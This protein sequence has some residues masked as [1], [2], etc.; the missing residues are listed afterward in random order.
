MNKIQNIT[1]C[2][3]CNLSF[4]TGYEHTKS[5]SL[6]KC[7]GCKY[8]FESKRTALHNGGDNIFFK[9]NCPAMM[10]DGRF[11]TMYDSTNE[12][13]ENMRKKLGIDNTN[14]FRNVIQD[15][16]N[17]II[18]SD[19]KNLYSNNSCTPSFSCSEGWAKLGLYTNTD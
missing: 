4:I 16:A 13:T 14:V 3:D 11:L 6:I 8:V 9:D 5:P 19:T 17:K 1:D 10:S 7:P 12:I 15:N 18:E 2:P